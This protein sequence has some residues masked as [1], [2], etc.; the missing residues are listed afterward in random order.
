MNNRGRPNVLC[1]K[2]V[3]KEVINLIWNEI[4]PFFFTRLVKKGLGFGVFQGNHVS[5][6]DTKTF[7]FLDNQI[8]GNGFCFT[9]LLENFGWNFK[10][11]SIM[12][13]SWSTSYD[14]CH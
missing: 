7:H 6:V 11:V 12:H 4:V 14:S 9:S 2:V 10:I 3:V 5:M 8:R 1:E 13:G